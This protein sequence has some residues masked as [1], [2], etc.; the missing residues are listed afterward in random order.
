MQRITDPTAQV[1]L[2]APPP[3]LGVLGYFRPA[4]IGIL[5]A[6]RLR[7]WFMNMIQEELMS[8]LTAAAVAPDTGATEFTAVVRSAQILSHQAQAFA[9]SGTFNV[10]SWVS[11]V[12][13]EMWGGGGGGGG[14]S[15]TGNAT[16]GGA[17]GAYARGFLNV[18]PGGT[19]AVT[20]GAAGA[21]GLATPAAGG[22]GGASSAGAISAA[23]GAGGLASAAANAGGAAAG[24]LINI[25]GAG[26]GFS[27][28]VTGG[29]VGGIGGS[30]FQGPSPSG[31]FNGGG[32]SGVAPGVGGNGSS[33]NAAGGTGAAGLVIIRW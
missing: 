13:V 15:A 17:G 28:A 1:T 26:G 10:P 16:T 21:G 23:G 20:V 25:G 27:L 14:A 11:R 32:I 12:D 2:P 29:M 24:G 5:A 8:F 33:A 19:L 6:T 30:S 4:T 22:A 7:Y 31:N 3:L 18:T 9:A